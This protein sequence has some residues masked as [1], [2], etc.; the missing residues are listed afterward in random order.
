MRINNY[1]YIYQFA[2]LT[3]KNCNYTIYIGST[4]IMQLAAT[5]QLA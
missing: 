3:F 4:A 2:K 1:N 5:K